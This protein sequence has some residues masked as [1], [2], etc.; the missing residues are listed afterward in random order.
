MTTFF[1]LFLTDRQRVPA[2]LAGSLLSGA[3]L[4]AAV[5]RVAWGVI[6]DRLFP[7]TRSRCLALVMTLTA[8][9]AGALAVLPADAALWLAGAIG[10]V[11]GF[12]AMGWQGLL[13]VVIAESVGIA[14]A[15]TAVGLLINVAW[16][17]FVLGP[18]V[19]GALAD[20]PGYVAAWVSVAVVSALCAAVLWRPAPV[21]ASVSPTAT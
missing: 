10:L 1:V 11:Y 19:F 6:A 21:G 2:P 12:C 13:M 4:A 5:G 3:L 9:A 18:V 7:T 20:G 15:G 16:V 17:G 14:L 8:L